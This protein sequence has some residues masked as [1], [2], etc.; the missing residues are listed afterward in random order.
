[1]W[2]YFRYSLIIMCLKGHFEMYY[3]VLHLCVMFVSHE[4]QQK[5]F[6]DK[7]SVC[8]ICTKVNTLFNQTKTKLDGGM[9]RNR[10]CV[11]CTVVHGLSPISPSIP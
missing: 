11:L 3:I 7:E 10:Q 4:V 9:F 5:N 8:D 1:M 6:H 2:M